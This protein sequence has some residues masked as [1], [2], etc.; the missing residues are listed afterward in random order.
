MS[1]LPTLLPMASPYLM[2]RQPVAIEAQKPVMLQ[3]IPESLGTLGGVL[4]L[5]GAMTGTYHGYIR[6][7]G[8]FGWALAWLAFG[9]VLPVF[10][11]P[12]SLA[13]GFGKPKPQGVSGLAGIFN[14]RR[15]WRRAVP[16]S[17][18]RVRY[19]RYV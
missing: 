1:N 12:I 14:R 7:N 6:N 9:S 16:R 19:R 10:S 18:P 13:Q 2:G 5:V 8:S 4:S 11:I 15:N 17:R 3:G